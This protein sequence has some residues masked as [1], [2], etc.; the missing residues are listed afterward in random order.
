MDMPRLLIALAGF[1][2]ALQLAPYG[3]QH[4]NPEVVRE[5]EWDQPRTRELFF[6][7]CRDCHSNETSWPWYSSIAPPPDFGRRGSRARATHRATWSTGCAIKSDNGL[8]FVSKR[9]QDRVGKL[10]YSPFPEVCVQ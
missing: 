4:D 1:G 9:V 2:L 3:R 5:P 6:R 7:A 8:E 10:H